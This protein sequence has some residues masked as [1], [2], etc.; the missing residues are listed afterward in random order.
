VRTADNKELDQMLPEDITQI[1]E[2]SSPESDD[3][4]YLIVRSDIYLDIFC[5]FTAQNIPS[6][7]HCKKMK[8]TV[9][10]IGAS[11]SEPG[12]FYLT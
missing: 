9:D 4:K 11:L 10:C 2:V 1:E 6:V 3:I 8:I 12:N 5:L 7:T